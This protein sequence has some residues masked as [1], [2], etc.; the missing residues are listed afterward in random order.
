[1]IPYTYKLRIPLVENAE[2]VAICELLLDVEF[3]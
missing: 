2:I 1:M 3:D